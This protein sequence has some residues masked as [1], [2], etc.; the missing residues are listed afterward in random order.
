ML[1]DSPL[2]LLEIEFTGKLNGATWLRIAAGID[3][4]IDGV[5]RSEDGRTGT[6]VTV[7]TG[8]IR[9]IEGVVRFQSQLNIPRAVRPSDRQILVDLKVGIVESRAVEKFR[10][11]F[12]KVPIG[13]W[14][15]VPGLNQ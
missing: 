5:D 7:R 14:V 2:Q 8:E 11:T 6:E 12:P 15:N 3:R 13:S 9:V 1:L 10:F 4:L